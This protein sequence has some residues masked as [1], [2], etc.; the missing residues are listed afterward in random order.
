MLTV[1]FRIGQSVVMIDIFNE[2]Y[3]NRIRVFSF[4]LK[5]GKERSG[6]RVT[7]SNNNVAIPVA[8]CPHTRARERARSEITKNIIFATIL[9]L[10]ACIR[11]RYPT[12]ILSARQYTAY[13]LR[14][15][16]LLTRR[17]EDKGTALTGEGEKRKEMKGK[18]E[19]GEKYRESRGVSR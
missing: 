19:R 16:N 14:N 18:G 8:H 9:S 3:R 10:R 4:F 5:F 2:L 15:C 11:L 6:A 1:I 17:R 7:F 12:K 13:N